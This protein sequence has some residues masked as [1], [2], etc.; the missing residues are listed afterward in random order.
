[1]LKL[2]TF[3]LSWMQKLILP[4]EGA[5]KTC[6]ESGI[7]L[8]FLHGNLQT[9]F[10]LIN[11]FYADS[12]LFALFLIFRF[13]IM[14]STGLWRS[15]HHKMG[16]H[17]DLYSPLPFGDWKSHKYLQNEEFALISICSS[18]NRRVTASIY[19]ISCANYST[20]SA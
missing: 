18:S 7:S 16:F 1:M 2:L 10:M 6:P 11:E 12:E 19:F 20:T 14:H 15:D 5:P 3:P 17:R 4:I 8:L 9:Y 13:V